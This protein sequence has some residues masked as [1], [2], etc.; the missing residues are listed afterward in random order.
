MLSLEHIQNYK[1]S[2]EQRRNEQGLLPEDWANLQAVRAYE[3]VYSGKV[4]EAERF[5]DQAEEVFSDE[6]DNQFLWEMRFGA[7][8]KK[9]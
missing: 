3:M 6:A 4:E 5:L 7:S 9:I 2:L 1:R 8:E